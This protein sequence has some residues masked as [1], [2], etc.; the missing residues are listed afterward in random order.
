[1]NSPR[2]RI[3]Y[4]DGRPGYVVWEWDKLLGHLKHSYLRR[5]VLRVEV[6]R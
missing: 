5:H 1:M 4:K 6:Y 2:Y 3:I